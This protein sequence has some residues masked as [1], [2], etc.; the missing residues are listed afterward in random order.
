LENSPLWILPLTD[1]RALPHGFH[2][3]EQARII[4][5]F[6][7]ASPGR[8]GRSAP[9][10][11]SSSPFSLIS[12]IALIRVLQIIIKANARSPLLATIPICGRIYLY[13]PIKAAIVAGNP[14]Q[15]PPSAFLK[16]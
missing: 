1:N 5:V 10:T 2:F 14:Q 4:P 8:Q 3:W 15:S 12:G 11:P 6:R 7:H 9:A 13:M 16:P